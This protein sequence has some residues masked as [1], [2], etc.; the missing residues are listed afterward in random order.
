MMRLR[1]ASRHGRQA[2][3]AQWPKV[4]LLRSLRIA[5]VTALTA[6]A[7]ASGAR[8]QQQAAAIRLVE[9]QADVS[10]CDFLGAVTDDELDDLRGKVVKLGG[11][12]ALL[13]GYTYVRERTSAFSRR[14]GTYLTAYAY[15][16]QK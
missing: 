9:N 11:D 6:C 12:T 3:D 8:V 5:L 2:E 16:C 4:P 13:A 14:K 10:G 15:R 7:C 1:R